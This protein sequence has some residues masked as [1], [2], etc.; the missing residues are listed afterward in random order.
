MLSHLLFASL[1]CFGDSV[2]FG[3]G[4]PLFHPTFCEQ[5]GGINSGVPSNDTSEALARIQTDVLDYNPKHVLIMFGLND[6]L[7]LHP[8]TFRNNLNKMIRLIHRRGGEPI[9]L[10]PNA[11]A[12]DWMEANMPPYLRIIRTTAKR[13]GLIL[14]DVHKA[15]KRSGNLLELLDSDLAHPR[16][17]GHD[18]IYKRILRVLKRDSL[19]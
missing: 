2:T 8:S 3:V 5:L 6:S 12:R 16:G 17:E 1:V 13:R 11:T 14:V 4:V 10:T 18:L 15:F 9:L 19:D 7:S